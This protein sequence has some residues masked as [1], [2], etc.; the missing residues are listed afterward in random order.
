MKNTVDKI[1][2]EKHGV[3]YT[4]IE[5]GLGNTLEYIEYENKFEISGTGCRFTITA[6]YHTKGGAGMEE[7]EIAHTKEAIK[8]K[9]KAVE[10][11]LL[12]NPQVYA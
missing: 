2:F 10:E 9:A 11:Y 7:Q 3:T 8:E 12:A 1:D 6:Q 5:G 4:T